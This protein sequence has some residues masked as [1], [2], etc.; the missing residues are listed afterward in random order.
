MLFCSLWRSVQPFCHQQDSP[1]R[2]AA[3]FADRGKRATHQ[4]YNL[5]STVE[6]LTTHEGPTLIGAKSTYC[7]KIAIFAQVWRVPDGILPW[8]LVRKN[9]NDVAT[10][11]QN[12]NW[13][14]VYSFYRNTRTWRTDRQTLHDRPRLCI[15]SRSKNWTPSLKFIVILVQC[16]FTEFV[17]WMFKYSNTQ[18]NWTIWYTHRL[19]T[20]SCHTELQPFENSQVFWILCC[21]L[22]K[23]W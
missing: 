23:I 11:R 9:L 2:G 6:M 18:K 16:R 21:L 17:Q 8:C 10:R 19:S 20:S 1:M 3:A 12:K 14:F 7:S 5:Y 22:R 15:S 4:C 13:R